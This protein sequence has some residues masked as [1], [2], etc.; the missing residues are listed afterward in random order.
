MHGF[1]SAILPGL[2]NSQNGPSW[3]LFVNKQW[4]YSSKMKKGIS[5]YTQSCNV[6]HVS[7]KLYIGLCTVPIGKHISQNTL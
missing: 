2:K 7:K 5:N 4:E 6:G 1:K 3:F